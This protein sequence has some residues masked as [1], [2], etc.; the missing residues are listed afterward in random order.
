MS[1]REQNTLSRFMPRLRDISARG[2]R[3]TAGLAIAA[4]YRRG[5]T[6]CFIDADNVPQWARREARRARDEWRANC[7]C[8]WRAE[9]AIP[10]DAQGKGRGGRAA[11]FQYAMVLDPKILQGAQDYNNCTSWCFRAVAGC[12]L[13][14]DIAARKELHAYKARP[15]TAGIYSWRG[16][17][18]DTGMAIYLGARAIHQHGIGLEINYPGIADLSTEAKDE[19]AGVQWGRSGPP[20][21]FRE[22]VK[23]DR[24]E[25]T[26]EVTEE[27]ALLDILHA[28]HFVGTGSTITARGAGDP[29]SPAGSV[30]GHAQALIGYDDTDEFRD[31]YKQTTGKKLDGWVGIFD[32]SWHPD[33]ITVKNWPDHL[34]GPKPEG[35][36]VLRGSDVLRMLNTRYGAAIACSKVAGFPVLDLPPWQ[37]ALNW[38]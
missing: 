7:G 33:W 11:N 25:Q 16:H 5:L 22:A 23:G 18:S 15:G 14:V 29:I 9:E 3:A 34:W 31:W 17:A 1:T 28:G 36:F 12:C 8:A 30:G 24:I 32:Q 37:D 10:A 20:A 13:A 35:A 26:S 6:G 27:E 21:A 38:M 4:A 19:L 2:V